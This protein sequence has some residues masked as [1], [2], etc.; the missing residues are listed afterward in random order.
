VLRADTAARAVSAQAW[1]DLQV[2]LL[3]GQVTACRR[4]ARDQDERDYQQPGDGNEGKDH[5]GVYAQRRKE[6]SRAR[7]YSLPSA[8]GLQDLSAP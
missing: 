7:L 5:F 3:Q 4:A 2:R 8:A 6:N 1:V